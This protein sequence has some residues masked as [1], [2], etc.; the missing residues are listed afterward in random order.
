MPNAKFTQGVEIEGLDACLKAFG[1]L[2]KEMRRNANGE[3]R[4][5]S[6]QIS[7]GLKQ[8]L[9]GS[10][11]PQ[12]PEILRAARPKADRYVVLKVPGVVPHM[13]GLQ[14]RKPRLK[15]QSD[16]A[17]SAA[18]RANA[19]VAR[20]SKQSIV[21]AIEDGTAYPPFHGPGKGSLVARNMGKAR[22]Y[23]EPV[24]GAALRQIMRKYGLL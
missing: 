19:R 23:A 15:P 14:K 6:K 8:F 16:K 9:G 5:A 3:L 2:E 21:W 17:V 10:G 24:Y 1:R 22:R 20:R 11:S 18:R 13:R 4:K 12:E 7:G